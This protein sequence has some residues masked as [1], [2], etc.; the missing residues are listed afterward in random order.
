MLSA[1]CDEG[2][3]VLLETSGALD[4]G[5][6]DERVIRIMDLKCPS[7]GEVDKNLWDNLEKL[8]ARDE[9]KFVV[10]TEEDYD[11][12]REVMTRRRMANRC[13]VLVSWAGPL[14]EAQRHPGLQAVPA[15]QRP[16]SLRTLAERVVADGLPVRMQVQMHKVIWPAD[17]RGV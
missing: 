15:G 11:W 13:T 10:G 14:S 8:R 16:L 6:V 5:G 2:F 9:V 1:L 3:T 12:M 7:S 17:Q 4:I